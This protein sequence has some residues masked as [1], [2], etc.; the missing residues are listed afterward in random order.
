MKRESVREMLER[1]RQADAQRIA[2]GTMD[3]FL[4]QQAAPKALDWR[5]QRSTAARPAMRWVRDVFTGGW[6][7]MG[8][9]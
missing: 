3:D 9:K 2:D 8:V 7:W 6:R 4:S 5:E 1:C